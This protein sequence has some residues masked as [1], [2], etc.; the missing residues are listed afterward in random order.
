MSDAQL[1]EVL[2]EALVDL[3]SPDFIARLK[4]QEHSAFAI[5]VS[6]QHSILIC[7][8]RA[9]VGD[10]IAEEVVQESWL[11]AFK[12]LPNFAERS[13]IKTWLYAIVS[14]HAKT[15][16]RKESR[17][18]SLDADGAEQDPLERYQFN[19]NGHWRAALPAWHIDSPDGLLEQAQLQKCIDKTLSLLPD[20]QR[21]VFTL[22]D[23]EQ[24][25]LDAICNILALSESNTR[26]LLHRARVK[27]MQVIAHYQ[28]TGRC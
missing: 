1:L 23:I 4:R 15:R 24:T 26:V 19:A 16:L 17:T 12:A 18:V 3:H 10:S 5:L 6:Q 11:A 27:L 2:E 20:Q 22:R 7:V 13:A 25:S 21:A 14:N 9:I 28:E 8:A